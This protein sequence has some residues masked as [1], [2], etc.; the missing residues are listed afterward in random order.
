MSLFHLL[1]LY[2][3]SESEAAWCSRNRLAV[4]SERHPQSYVE[5][6][7]DLT[8][9]FLWYKKLGYSQVWSLDSSMG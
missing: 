3:F 9:A 7:S 2:I 4:K 5:S 1:S 6:W 8:A